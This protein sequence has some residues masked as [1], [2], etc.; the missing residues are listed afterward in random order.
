MKVAY[1]SVTKWLGYETVATK[2]P[3][4]SVP[5]Q[6]CDVSVNHFGTYCNSQWRIYNLRDLRYNSDL[7]F[8]SKIISLITIDILNYKFIQ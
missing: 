7:S 3:L 2:W 4:R 8:R 6:F 5:V 1:C